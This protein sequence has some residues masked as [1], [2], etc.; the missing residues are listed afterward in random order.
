MP[1]IAPPPPAAPATIAAAVAPPAVVEVLARDLVP[2]AEMPDDEGYRVGSRH[3]RARL[4]EAKVIEARRLHR[5]GLGY[6]ALVQR[7]GVG[8]VTLFY[9]ISGRTWAHVPMEE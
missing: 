5:A 1:A 6:P 4:D 8:K 9:A 2:V 3:G 7:F